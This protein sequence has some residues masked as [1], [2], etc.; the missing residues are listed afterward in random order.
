MPG[1]KWMLK[2]KASLIGF[3]KWAQT[4]GNLFIIYSYTIYEYPWYKLW[5]KDDV[6]VKNYM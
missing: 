4:K 5:L 6:L 1:K 2:N 3:D